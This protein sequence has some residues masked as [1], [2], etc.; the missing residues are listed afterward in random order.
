VNASRTSRDGFGANPFDNTDGR[1]KD[2]LAA[3]VL[4]QSR[5]QDNS[6]VG[7]GGNII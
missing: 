3:E 2:R 6:L 7:L 5:R 1:Q 4:D